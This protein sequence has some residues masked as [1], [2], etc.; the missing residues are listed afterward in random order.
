MRRDLISR[1]KRSRE[2]ILILTGKPLER[3][4]IPAQK[5]GLLLIKET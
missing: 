2:W 1:C 4:K 5:S 3:I